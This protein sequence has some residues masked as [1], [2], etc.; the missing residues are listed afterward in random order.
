M[1][2][3]RHEV[4]AMRTKAEMLDELKVMLYD[5]LLAKAQGA[6]APRLA[7]AQ[8]LADGYMTALLE[9]GI[10]SNQEL[11]SLVADARATVDGPAVTSLS[12]PDDSE[13]AA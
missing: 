5:A 2:Q 1:G 11:L 9:A 6:A 13:V 4:D 10:A 12:T 7:R 3:V 8:G